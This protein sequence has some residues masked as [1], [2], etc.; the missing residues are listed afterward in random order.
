MEVLLQDLGAHNGPLRLVGFRGRADVQYILP[1]IHLECDALNGARV[2]DA[3]DGEKMDGI[4]C[5]SRDIKGPHILCFPCE[6][7]MQD[8]APKMEKYGRG[9]LPA[10]YACNADGLN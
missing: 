4:Y 7:I 3:W 8:V 1:G 2:T 5:V 9:L 10:V 6:H